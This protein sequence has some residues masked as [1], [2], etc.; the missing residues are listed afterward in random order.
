MLAFWH[1]Q[2]PILR[3]G[4]QKKTIAAFFA[5]C[6]MLAAIAWLYH[7]LARDI[8]KCHDLGGTVETTI[9]YPATLVHCNDVNGDNML[10]AWY[11]QYD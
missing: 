3:T 4:D 6:F 9:I 10:N 8:E 7:D 5:I 11:K 1:L 2:K